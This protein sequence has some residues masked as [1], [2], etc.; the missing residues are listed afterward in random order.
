[1][2]LVRIAR[3]IGIMVDFQDQATAQMAGVNAVGMKLGNTF[4]NTGD[5]AGAMKAQMAAAVV[6]A[7]LTAIA[8]RRIVRIGA[9]VDS[10]FAR[11]ETTSRAT[12]AEMEEVVETTRRIGAEMPVTMHQVAS[13]M[14]QFIF[15]GFEVA[16][17]VEAADAAVNLSIAGQMEMADAVRITGQIM[18][19][20]GI[21]A[22]SAGQITETLGHIFANHAISI[23]EL[24][25]AMAYVS[26]TASQLGFD[27]I[28]LGA[29]IGVIADQGIQGTMAGTSLNQALT[30]LVNPTDAA[31]DAMNALGLSM[32][33]FTDEE[34]NM[35]DF[36]TIFEKLDEHTAHLGDQA[37]TAWFAE[38]FG[39]RGG[40]AV[41]ALV[42]DVDKL[43]E[44]IRE[45]ALVQLLEA[46][47]TFG[48][49]D[50]AAE[51]RRAILLEADDVEWAREQ[52]S[53]MEDEAIIDWADQLGIDL[54]DFQFDEAIDIIEHFREAHA[55]GMA[56]E[57]VAQY[58]Q[59]LFDLEDQA[60]AVLAQ[61]IVDEDTP[62]ED[63]EED[64]NAAVGAADIAAAQL[65]T[66]GG[67]IE[68]LRGSMTSIAYVIYTGFR[69]A[70]QIALYA[71]MG[72]ADLLQAHPAILKAVGAAMS[73]VIGLIIAW[74]AAMLN[75]AIASSGLTKAL[76]SKALALD[77]TLGYIWRNVA[78]LY[79]KMAATGSLT[80]A[81][82]VFTAAVWK[83]VV[84]LKAKAAALFL[85]NPIGWAVLAV[86]LLL[87]A[88]TYAY[89]NN[90]YGFATAV[91][92]VR[93]R[94]GG[95]LG[96]VRDLVNWFRNLTFT[97]KALLAL[98]VLFVPVLGPKLA[99]LIGIYLAVIV[100]IKVFKWLISAVRRVVGWIR[101]I[102]DALGWF[103]DRLR[104]LFPALNTFFALLSMYRQAGGIIGLI[105]R[106]GR[107]FDW[108]T[109]KIQRAIIEFVRLP[110]T[111][112]EGLKDGGGL[113]YQGILGMLGPFARLFPSSDAQ[114]GPLSNLT[115]RAEKI[116]II[117]AR[118]IL[119]RGG[120]VFDAMYRVAKWALAPLE[121]I[122]DVGEKI[123]ET[124]RK[125]RRID[126]FDAMRRGIQRVLEWIDD[127]I[128][129]WLKTIYTR[130][131]DIY[132]IFKKW[133]GPLGDA[134]DKLEKAGEAMPRIPT[135]D[136]ETG[137]GPIGDI[138][139]TTI[140]GLFP[141]VKPI[142]DAIEGGKGII[143]GIMDIFGGDDDDASEGRIPPLSTTR[144]TF[145]DLLTTD[146]QITGPS[147]MFGSRSTAMSY[148]PDISGGAQIDARKVVIEQ[149]PHIDIDMHG[150]G[151]NAD[152]VRRQVERGM[153]Q[154]RAGAVQDF[155]DFLTLGAPGR[156]AGDGVSTAAPGDDMFGDDMPT[157]FDEEGEGVPDGEEV[158]PP[159][160]GDS[161]QPGDDDPQF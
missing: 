92:W 29:A 160:N 143:D 31:T 41:M 144:G 53:Q 104:H 132:D 13:A 136:D 97:G 62:V 22:E 19:A 142:G 46:H 122:Y 3:R 32:G 42:D 134:L 159:E 10:T 148:A 90:L 45:G 17:A 140:E 124:F 131:K 39:I 83:S 20:Y 74:V 27:V 99:L 1:M 60:A 11:I 108:V 23:Q 52:L 109:G 101:T 117:I 54:D 73:V 79:A 51:A 81:I 94:M 112:Y 75:A 110:W 16:E 133:L 28:E 145:A 107:G 128:P 87:A 64:L 102:A 37:R 8:M 153:E 155:Y 103:L 76:W 50:D 84:A 138:G 40:R 123:Y 152:S 69:P 66:V 95:F 114:E 158:E 135:A 36:L 4:R 129:N 93:D 113:I 82:K 65:E 21:E 161:Q 9:Q 56:E 71:L 55:D 156:F 14:E 147:G 35:V 119:G 58:L 57:E 59:S 121:K 115:E 61:D 139:E 7:G 77:R 149:S 89:M 141:W 80:G 18:N 26:A 30:S 5:Q 48:D 146:A 100:L 154:A 70:L 126:P 111:I 24:G 116:P 137:L 47:D 125:L 15:A 127:R 118:A 130:A 91:D 106:I 88:A 105:R 49:L 38:V 86:L 72:L 44:S 96:I 98:M 151:A 120:A 33:D 12:S 67:Q 157:E 25:N 150:S 78:A 85:S 34:G 63:L 68:Y 2:G 43:E 6:V